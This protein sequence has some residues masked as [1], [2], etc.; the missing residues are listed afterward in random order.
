M[1]LAFLALALVGCQHIPRVGYVEVSPY[2]G[3]GSIS[4]VGQSPRADSEHYGVMVTLGFKLED[5]NER[6]GWR[7]MARLDDRFAEL[8]RATS[9]S[10]GETPTINLHTGDKVTEDDGSDF[11]VDIPEATK[12]PLEALAY[13][14][15]A[16]AIALL[17]WAVS[18]FWIDRRKKKPD[19]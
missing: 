11:P 3:A 4:R 10:N 18:T 7:S 19:A 8:L 14:L 16:A 1:R 6:E 2:G 15:W 12:D 17:F 5:R 9:Q 13:L